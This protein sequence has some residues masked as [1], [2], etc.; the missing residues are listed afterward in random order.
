MDKVAKS[1]VANCGTFCH[2]LPLPP[3]PFLKIRGI[4]TAFAI[5]SLSI[6]ENQGLKWQKFSCRS[7]TSPVTES[8][9][10]NPSYRYKFVYDIV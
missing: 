6:F 2:F 7:P 1:G 5:V 10:R 4:F 9:V 3:C 8:Y